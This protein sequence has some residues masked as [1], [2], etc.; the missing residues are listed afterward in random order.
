[1]R[2]KYNDLYEVS[3]SQDNVE[4]LNV[5]SFEHNSCWKGVTFLVNYSKWKLFILSGHHSLGNLAK[6]GLGRSLAG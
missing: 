6:A 1:M 3:Q 5:L 2:E 4:L